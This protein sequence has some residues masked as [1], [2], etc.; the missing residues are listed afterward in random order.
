[1]SDVPL[2]WASLFAYLGATV[3]FALGIAASRKWVGRAALVVLL[4]GFSVHTLA[5]VVRSVLI[6]HPPFTS[7]YEYASCLSWATVLF[8][9]ILQLREKARNLGAFVAPLAFAVIVVASLFPKDMERQLVPALQSYW[10]QIHVTLAVVA[11]G[12]FA[13]AFGSS[14]MYLLKARGTRWLPPLESLDDL[15]YKA[16]LLGYP[17]FTLGALFA[18]AVW[19]WKAWGRPWGWDPKEVGS[20]VVWLIYS[21]YLHA[22]ITAGWRGKRAAVLAILGFAAAVFT[23]LSNLFIGGL[24]AY[25]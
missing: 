10:L 19:A 21:A 17:L 18:G 1:M 16:I 23:F 7:M 2:F 14:V 3:L 25:V 20:L 9:F 24:H 13:V 4:A 11:E 15:T 12:A 6:G 5:L 22:R 8:Y